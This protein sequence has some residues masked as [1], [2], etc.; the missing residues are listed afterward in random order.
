MTPEIFPIRFKKLFISAITLT[1]KTILLMK[2]CHAKTCLLSITCEE[3]VKTADKIPAFE[4]QW[5]CVMT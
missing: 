2:L 3:I 4:K 1:Q 5:E